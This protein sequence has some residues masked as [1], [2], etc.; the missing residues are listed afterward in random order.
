MR[1]CTAVLRRAGEKDGPSSVG[2]THHLSQDN[3]TS[4]R[5]QV[6]L[7]LSQPTFI[8]IGDGTAIFSGLQFASIGH[9]V[10]SFFH[11][12]AVDQ[13][14]SDYLI[15][16]ILQTNLKRGSPNILHTDHSRK[17]CGASII[18]Y[19]TDGNGRSVGTQ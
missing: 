2:V 10:L 14:G 13:S 8:M 16:G 18:L 15:A 3:W 11:N 17:E 12:D 4:V 1:R 19:G 9:G 5:I 6:G 7:C